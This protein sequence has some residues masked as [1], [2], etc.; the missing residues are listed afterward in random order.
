MYKILYGGSITRNGNTVFF[1]GKNSHAIKLHLDAEGFKP[2]KG[3]VTPE[4]VERFLPLA[5]AQIPVVETKNNRRGKKQRNKIYKITENGITYTLV[6]AS[7]GE[8][9]SFYSNK[10]VNKRRKFAQP[11]ASATGM[12]TSD[13][14]S[15]NPENASSTDKNGPSAAPDGAMEGKRTGTDRSDKSDGNGAIFTLNSN[16]SE[17][18]KRQVKAMQACVGPFLDQDGAEYARRFKEKYGI[19]NNIVSVVLRP[20]GAKHTPLFLKKDGGLGEGKNF[21]SREKK[22]FPSPKNSHYLLSAAIFLSIVGIS[23]C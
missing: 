21:F 8:F 17:E 14:I 3:P 23:I 16:A 7:R 15:Q 13:N 19:T 1:D 5:L 12:L 20:M 2:S 22:F 9:R 10:K 11:G 6:T 18:L 4:E